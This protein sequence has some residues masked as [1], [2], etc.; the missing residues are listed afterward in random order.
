[1]KYEGKLAKPMPPKPKQ[2]RDGSSKNENS[3]PLLDPEEWLDDVFEELKDRIKLLCEVHDVRW[4]VSG[5]PDWHALALALAGTHVPGFKLAAKR[6]RKSLNDTE[7]ARIARRHLY[8]LVEAYQNGRTGHEASDKAALI[9]L[10]KQKPSRV[11]R[12][13]N[14]KDIGTL[15]TAVVRERRERKESKEQAH[16]FRD[17][18][19]IDR[20]PPTGNRNRASKK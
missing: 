20:I 4:T 5:G 19:G 14:D 7:Q 3:D 15:R 6:G 9:N 2:R 13:F 12:F 17:V 8:D 1:M 10:R 16:M 18:F 11:P